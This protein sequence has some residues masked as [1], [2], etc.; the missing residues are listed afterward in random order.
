[1]AQLVGLP[2]ELIQYARVKSDEMHE[3]I[4]MKKK[5]IKLYEFLDNLHI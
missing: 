4:E 1:M 5:K 2:K 3:E